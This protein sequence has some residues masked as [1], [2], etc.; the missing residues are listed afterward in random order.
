MFYWATLELSN[1]VTQGHTISP[2]LQKQKITEHAM[3]EN[4]I[5]PICTMCSP[6]TSVLSK[7]VAKKRTNR[8]KLQETENQI[9]TYMYNVL[10]AHLRVVNKGCSK[11]HNKLKSK[12]TKP[13]S[14]RKTNQTHM[15]QSKTIY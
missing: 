2:N 1:M 8:S 9:K 5:K 3:T 7:M 6:S 10:L 14:N 11:R 4:Q 13:T 15:Y 12:E